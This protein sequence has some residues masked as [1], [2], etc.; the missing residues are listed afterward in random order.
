MKKL[1]TFKEVIAPF[2][3]I[4]VAIGNKPAPDNH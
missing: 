4:K 3:C 2:G 1:K